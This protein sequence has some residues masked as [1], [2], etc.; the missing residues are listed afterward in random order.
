MVDS[1]KK[2]IRQIK[3]PTYTSFRLSKPLKHP[4][5]KIMSSR[6]LLRQ[7]FSLL[8]KYKSLFVGIAA[9]FGVVQ[10]LLV[11]GVL[12]ADFTLIVEYVQGALQQDTVGVTGGLTLF[13]YLLSSSMEGVSAEGGVYQSILLVIFTL[14]LVWAL[15]NT[16]AGTKVRVRDAYYKGMYPLIPFIL[17]F[18]VVLLQLLPL[19]VGAW[20]YETMISAGV[21]VTIIEQLFWLIIAG[22]FALLTFYMLCSSIIAL[23]IVMLPDMTPMKALR[24]ARELVQYRRLKVFWRLVVLAISSLLFVALFVLPTIVFATALAPWVFYISS[25]AVIVVVHSYLYSLYRE[26]LRDA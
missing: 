7:A 26:L 12:A 3:R 22:L 9:V 10:L 19:L 1:K 14:A 17:V 8:G 15:R 18:L 11:Q 23:Y 25:V 24:S 6:A 13:A 5:S 2:S 4:V 16:M 21:A 20:L